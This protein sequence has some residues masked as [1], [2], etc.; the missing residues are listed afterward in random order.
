MISSFLVR[1]TLQS[2]RG[3]SGSFAFRSTPDLRR[4]VLD[5]TWTETN[6]VF[7]MDFRELNFCFICLKVL[8]SMSFYFRGL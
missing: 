2:R 6:R 4:K 7:P 1:E 3:N 8:H 5:E